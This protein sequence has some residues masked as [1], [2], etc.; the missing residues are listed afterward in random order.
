MT[1]SWPTSVIIGVLRVDWAI[2]CLHLE[3]QPN[4]L[5]ALRDA[6]FNRLG[7]QELPTELRFIVALRLAGQPEDF[8]EDSQRALRAHLLDPNMEEIINMEFEA[9]VVSDPPEN[10]PAGWEVALTYPVVVNFQA[11]EVGSYSIDFYVNDR[12]QAGT[13]VALWVAIDPPATS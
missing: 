4:G 9:P 1:A 6:C 3:Q 12:F 11:T 8:F 2:P 5:L 7:V 13:S 10:H